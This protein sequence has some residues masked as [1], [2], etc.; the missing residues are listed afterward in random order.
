MDPR[1]FP[2]WAG[3]V[4]RQ[5]PWLPLALLSGLLVTGC[6]PESPPPTAEE[7]RKVLQEAGERIQQ[8]AKSAAAAARE[9][10][11]DATHVAE[12]LAKRA[13]E[14]THRITDAA[15]HSETAQ[16]LKAASTNAFQQIKTQAQAGATAARAQAELTFKEA[17]ELATQAAAKAEEQGRKLA[18]K[19]RE[20]LGKSAPKP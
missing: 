5:Q 12:S 18:E 17:S 19:T 7:T 8:G 3:P 4:H 2:G 15:A 6:S 11:H 14:E 1:N 10:A 13:A 16:R 9:T 20:T